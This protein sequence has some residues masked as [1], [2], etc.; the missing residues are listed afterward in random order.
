MGFATPAEIVRFQTEL[1]AAS[2]TA[3]ARMLREMLPKIRNDELH[4]EF[5]ALLAGIIQAESKT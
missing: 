1:A 5:A 3:K 4:A 2:D